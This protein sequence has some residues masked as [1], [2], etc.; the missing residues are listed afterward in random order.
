MI[1][2]LKAYWE[3]L[4][5]EIPV[6]GSIQYARCSQEADAHSIRRE[7]GDQVHHVDHAIHV[8]LTAGMS[9]PA[10]RS[11]AHSVNIKHAAF[12]EI[13]GAVLVLNPGT[14]VL[15]IV[16]IFTDAAYWEDEG[17]V[18]VAS[19]LNMVAMLWGFLS[20]LFLL[21]LLWRASWDEQRFVL[22]ATS[23]YFVVATICQL[24]LFP[25]QYSMHKSAYAMRRLLVVTVNFCFLFVVGFSVLGIRGTAQLP[26]GLHVLQFFFNRGS[27][28]W[29]ALGVPGI[30]IQHVWLPRLWLYF[31]ILCTLNCSMRMSP[32]V[33]MDSSFDLY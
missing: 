31:F 9:T 1:G 16:L 32:K 10:L 8:L 29:N 23:K 18:S 7:I 28:T 26:L 4:C 27:N 13:I 30:W 2:D 33:L 5:L 11:I 20:R 14:L 3:V 6:P 21:L 24:L 17:G 25:F 22:K 15:Y 19:V 12:A